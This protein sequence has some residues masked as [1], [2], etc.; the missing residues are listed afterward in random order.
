MVGSV[1]G[2]REFEDAQD[3][4]EGVVKVG[5]I[6]EIECITSVM[7]IEGT[8]APIVKQRVGHLL[9]VMGAGLYIVL[10]DRKRTQELRVDGKRSYQETVSIVAWFLEASDLGLS[11]WRE[12]Q[13]R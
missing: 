6:A 1:F 5:I 11:R 9:P 3:A 2:I 13:L 12:E 7:I 10:A 4:V 8:H